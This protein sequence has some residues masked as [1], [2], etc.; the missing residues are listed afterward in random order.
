MA[1]DSEALWGGEGSAAMPDDH[2]NIR[3]FKGHG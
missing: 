2:M 3:M 1:I